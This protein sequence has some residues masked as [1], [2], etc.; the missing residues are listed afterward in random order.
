M[1]ERE[2]TRKIEDFRELGIPPYVPREDPLHLV[3]QMVSTVIGARRAGKSYRVLQ[4][5]SE[6]IE[7]GIISS[8][9]QICPLDF[10]NPI[11]AHMSAADLPQIQSCF[12]KL[13]PAFD[14]RTPLVFILD[15]IHK[16][17]GW[18]EYVIDL[19]RNR[20][21]RVLVTGSSSRLLREDLATE[22][23]GKAISSVVYPLSFGEFLKFREFGHRPGSTKGQAEICRLFDEYLQ[24]GGYPAVVRIE[25]R[26]REALLREYFDTMILRDI[27]QRYDASKPQQCIRL[28]RYLLANIGKGHTF[29]SAYRYLRQC[30]FSTSRDAVRDYVTWARDSW[31]LFT[32]P[33][34]SDSA[35]DQERNYR[36]L[37]AIDWALALKNSL[38]WDGSHSQALENLVFI[39]LAR[40]WS[41]VHYYLTGRKRQEVDFIAVDTGGRPAMAVQVCMDLTREEVVQRELEPLLATARY[42]GIEENWIVTYDQEEDFSR[43]GIVIR[44][45][46]AW[47]WLLETSKE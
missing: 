19:S 7:K 34:F 16:I 36:K 38:V 6:L 20:H 4:A 3:D 11:L 42:F 30:G 12:L 47:K 43:D 29:Q 13:N 28:Y 22:L 2:I 23:R 10:D 44:A 5:A 40:R 15:E 1:F 39:H 33:I 25:A 21:W 45:V 41:R 14:L 8:I 32:V 9:D 24:W 17:S 18:E 37:Y 26:T 27:L 46:P 35:K 31:L